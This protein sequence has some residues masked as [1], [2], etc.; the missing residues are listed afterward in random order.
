MRCAIVYFEMYGFPASQVA[1]GTNSWPAARSFVVRR[2]SFVGRRWVRRLSLVV[3]RLSF[4]RSSFGICSSA[5]AALLRCSVATAL[6]RCCAALLL[7]ELWCQVCCGGSSGDVLLRC[8]A[9]CGACL[10]RCSVALLP[11]T[12]PGAAY[13]TLALASALCN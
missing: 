1:G 12:P 4:V 5:A 8:H 10:L 3:R 6:L 9:C 11:R 13:A 2:S 7:L